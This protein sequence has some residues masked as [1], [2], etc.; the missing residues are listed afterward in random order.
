[1][2][3]LLSI[4]PEYAEKIFSGEKR[5]EFRKRKPKQVV[6]RVFVYECR[7]SKRIVGWF[8]V[9][10]IHSGPPGEI[11]KRCKDSGGIEEETYLSYCRGKKVVHALEID[12][13][14]RFDPPMNPVEALSDFKPPQDFM[15]FDDDMES[16]EKWQC[17]MPQIVGSRS[18]ERF[19]Y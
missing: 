16:S 15:Y 8:S 10:K 17:M 3:V 7:P 9:S 19:R 18:T 13:I 1:M 11:W 4:K 2:N 14:F 5:Y 6:N 12:E